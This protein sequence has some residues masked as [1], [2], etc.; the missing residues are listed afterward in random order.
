MGD[1]VVRHAESVVPV[2][3][4]PRATRLARLTTEVFAPGILVMLILLVIGAASSRTPLVGLA[5]GAG[6]ALL[7]GAL[8]YGLMILGARRGWLGDRHIRDRRQRLIPLAISTASVGIGLG[9]LLA[10]HGPHDVLALVVTMLTALI[11]F[12]LITTVW[13]ISFHTGVAAG[14]V[15]VLV[16]VFGPVLL[17]A[18]PVVALVAWSRVHL[19]DHTPAQVIAGALLG[20]TLT[21]A[22][23]PTLR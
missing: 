22:L 14:N 19:T 5:W 9:L 13:K 21:I 20:T 3:D 7:C 10:W 6:A 4:Q 16:I 15:T 11:V 18:V 1:V 8:P 2:G 17:L 12:T 23:F